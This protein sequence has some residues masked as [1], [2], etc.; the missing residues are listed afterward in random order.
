[1]KSIVRMLRKLYS[2]PYQAALVFS[3]TLVAALTIAVGTWVISNTINN[4]LSRVMNER[5]ARDA[6]LAVTFY[7]LRLREISSVVSQ[8]SSDPTIADNLE[9]ATS[10]NDA[11]R[12]A[13]EAEIL[14]RV[15]GGMPGVSCFVA[16]LDT[17]GAVMAGA[18]SSTDGS[19]T[20][21]TPGGNWGG[22]P[23][24]RD[25]LAGKEILASTEIIPQEYLVMIDLDQQAVVALLNTPKAA[26][27]PYDPREGTA[28][29]AIFGA[30]P[31]FDSDG[32]L[33]GVA[34]AFHM[35][36]N[37][38]TIVDQIKDAAQI[39]T[40]TIFLGDLRVSTNVMTET[41]ER[42]VGTRL[43]Q[44][45]T[46]VVLRQG[47]EYVG[48]AF[49]VNQDYITRYE[50]LSD[51]TGQV[52]GVLYVGTPKSLFMQLLNTL[53]QQILLVAVVTILMTFILATPVSRV[54]TRPLKDLRE[55]IRAS[56][57]V[58]EG[59]LDARASVTAGG[60]VGLVA[61]SFNNMLDALHSTREQL[62]HSENL[63]S[64]GQLAAGVAHELNNPLATVLLYSESMLKEHEEA[65]PES[66]DLQT[67]ISETKRCK[68][69]V[70][71]LLNFARQTQVV[72]QPTDIHAIID[73]LLEIAPRRIK[74]VKVD[75]VKDFDP[76]LPIIEGDPLQLRQVLSN[77]LVNAVEAMP[78]GGT[79]TFRTRNE[80]PGMIT[81]EIQDT[82][83]GVP[84]ESLNK[85]FTPFFTTKPMGKG[86]GLG[87]SIVYGI[88]K[89]HRGQIHAKSQVD[90]GTTF[91][92]NLPVHLTPSGQGAPAGR[93]P[94]TDD[95]KTMIG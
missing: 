29:L 38:F 46:D 52:V 18:L 76:N 51:H 80:P 42:A 47:T 77:L 54:I 74:T 14:A 20:A 48:E 31:I 57:R 65:D 87:L 55:L 26:P 32:Q 56:R 45:V 50:P 61:K 33:L 30:A 10:G 95:K 1:M 59:D 39:D 21:V 44:E 62:I 37:D 86:T 70:S 79:V 40:V 66:K 11:A 90:K 75:F 16:I 34:I 7:D 93:F 53:N 22:L 83:V 13:L 24:V 71:D 64:L 12:Q 78:D 88:V 19:Q 15:R 91:T 2:G 35:F 3:F 84:P 92:I 72:A 67:I 43:S 69:I 58:V 89:M 27:Q 8:L 81:I 73:E 28:G 49:V 9:A 94:A 36:N 60:E 23:I 85:L 17:R 41:G 25:A 63:A 6:H 5:V 82:G 68:R 4:Y